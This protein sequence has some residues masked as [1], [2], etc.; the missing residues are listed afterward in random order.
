MLLFFITH[1][2][3]SA[4]KLEYLYKK[5]KKLLLYKAYG[6][7]RDYN[8]SEDIVS[9]TYIKIQKNIDKIDDVDSKKS[10]SFL[11]VI[12]KN[13]ALNY[14]KKYKTHSTIED[15]TDSLSD[16]QDVENLVMTRKIAKDVLIIVDCLKEELKAPFLLKYTHGLSH[17]EIAKTLNITENNATVRIYRAKT[18]IIKI[19]REGGYADEIK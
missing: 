10:V 18:K 1:V 19:L 4:E 8:V 3:N 16:K 17:N 12:L 15:Y 6:I 9:E 5:Y 2:L 13:T 11:C 14:V 7:C